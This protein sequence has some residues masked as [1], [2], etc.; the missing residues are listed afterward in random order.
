MAENKNK[1][2][3]TA[4][5]KHKENIVLKCKVCGKKMK[6]KTTLS[7]HISHA[8]DNMKPVDR[9]KIVID[10]YYGKDVVDRTIR[11]IKNGEFKNKAVPIDIGRYLRL[12]GIKYEEEDPPKKH[13][14]LKYDAEPFEYSDNTDKLF[15]Q[16]RDISEKESHDYK[17]D[18]KVYYIDDLQLNR[19]E[20]KIYISTTKGKT[21]AMDYRLVLK[22]IE[23]MDVKDSTIYVSFAG[24]LYPVQTVDVRK[25]DEVPGN[26]IKCVVGY[27][28]TK[29]N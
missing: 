16:V 22:F 25:D 13:D 17:E 12:A 3:K 7:R 19:K 28:S 11:K 18:K 23:E 5:E 26:Q 4:E 29:E 9:E 10:T 15:V 8:H 20:N 2:F 1:Q 14:A 24:N 21:S 27:D 6:G